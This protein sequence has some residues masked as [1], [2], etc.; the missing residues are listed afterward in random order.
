MDSLVIKY[1]RKLAKKPF[2]QS[3]YSHSKEC[4]VK[5]LPNDGEYTDLQVCFLNYLAFYYSLQMDVSLGEVD[6]NVFDD[7][8]YE[9]A[10]Q[11]YKIKLSKEKDKDKDKKVEDAPESKR[12]IFKSPKG[13]K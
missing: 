3:L 12:F 7:D 11:C 4:N 9:D 2:Y 5:L 1:I 13:K 6:K 8:L 10:Y